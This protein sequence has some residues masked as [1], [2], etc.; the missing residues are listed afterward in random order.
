MFARLTLKAAFCRVYTDWRAFAGFIT[1]MAIC[2]TF[3][4]IGDHL[5]THLWALLHLWLHWPSHVFATDP[6]P[7]LTI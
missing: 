6:S 2:I 7:I 4:C 3:K 1:F 5:L